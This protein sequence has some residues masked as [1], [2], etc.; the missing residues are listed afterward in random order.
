MEASNDE[1][2]YSEHEVDTKIKGFVNLLQESNT[3]SNKF[4]AIDKF[5]D[6]MCSK[7]L[8]SLNES[9]IDLLFEGNEEGIVG[10]CQFAGRKKY[11]GRNVKRSSIAALTMIYKLMTKS[12]NDYLLQI[13]QKSLMIERFTALDIA[14]YESMNLG[15]HYLADY[16][17]KAD[18]NPALEILYIL[19]AIFKLM[20][21]RIESSFNLGSL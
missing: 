12:G 21:R 18:I 2:P 5:C 4:E 16:N 8:F 11:L 3:T 10:L 9:Q 15:K 7:K 20:Y 13:A 14:V 6:F 19:K 1:E 17:K